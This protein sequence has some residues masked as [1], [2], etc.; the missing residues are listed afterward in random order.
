MPRELT[1]REAAAQT[2]AL[3]KLMDTKAPNG[4]EYRQIYVAFVRA[5]Q[6]AAGDLTRFTVEAALE[7]R[8]FVAHREA[9]EYFREHREKI[10]PLLRD[11][12]PN[13][14]L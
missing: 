1:L 8:N 14:A 11:A 4:E 2:E 13:S 10:L 6:Q 9:Y 7:D 3:I 12:F 5:Y